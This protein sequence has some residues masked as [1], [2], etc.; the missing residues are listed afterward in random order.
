VKGDGVVGGCVGAK[1]G[2]GP[3]YHGLVLFWRRFPVIDRRPLWNV[4]RDL[5]GKSAVVG[6]YEL[7]NWIVANHQWTLR[8]IGVRPVTLG[9]RPRSDYLLFK[10]SLLG[11]ALPDKGNANAAITARPSKLR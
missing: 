6:E 1:V 10:R 11:T 3:L 9:N 8:A 7:T 5:K 4:S 2:H